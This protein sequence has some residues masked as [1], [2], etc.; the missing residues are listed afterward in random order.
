M[1]TPIKPFAISVCAVGSKAG[2]GLWLSVPIERNCFDA[3]PVC[4]SSDLESGPGDIPSVLFDTGDGEMW[5]SVGS[6]LFGEPKSI[7]IVFNC[8]CVMNPFYIC[9]FCI[10]LKTIHWIILLLSSAHSAH[11]YSASASKVLQCSIHKT[12]QFWF[13]FLSKCSPPLAIIFY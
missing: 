10:Y 6:S 1:S 11:V 2:I 13:I 5:K 4:S 3:V 7:L 8:T 12:M 9:I